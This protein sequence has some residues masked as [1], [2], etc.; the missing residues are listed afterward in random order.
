MIR[1]RTDNLANGLRNGV[2]NGVHETDGTAVHED[3][4]KYLEARIRHI[5]GLS[6]EDADREVHEMMREFDLVSRD[7]AR[8]F[9]RPLTPDEKEAYR[10]INEIL[11]VPGVEPVYKLG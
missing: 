9:G 11:H 5:E 2:V 6:R 1:A 10:Q 3:L 4:R 7:P 8:L